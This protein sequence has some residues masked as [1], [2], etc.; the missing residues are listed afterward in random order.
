MAKNHG[1]YTPAKKLLIQQCCQRIYELAA[2][3][4]SPRT[5]AVQL[6]M[7]FADYQTLLGQKEA[8]AFVYQHAYEAGLAKYEA[9]NIERIEAVLD[10]PE[11]SLGLKYKAARENLK[12]LEHHA[13]ATRAVKVQVE[14]AA[15]VFTFEAYSAEEQE[16]IKAQHNPD[17]TEED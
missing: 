17:D 14:D 8:D 3:N 5:I 4:H 15:S 16:A 13:P 11:A 7:S 9:D 12:E 6:G 2:S 1:T 10:D